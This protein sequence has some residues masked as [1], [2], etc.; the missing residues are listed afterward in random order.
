MCHPFIFPPENH[1]TTTMTHFMSCLLF[2]SLQLLGLTHAGKDVFLTPSHTT[3][4]PVGVVAIEGAQIPNDAYIPLL[5]ALQNASAPEYSVY[6]AIPSFLLDCPNPPQISSKIAGARKELLAAM[7]ATADTKIVG[8]AHSLGAVFLQDFVFKNPTQFSAQ[9]LT[10]AALG[11]KYRNGSTGTGVYPVPTMAIDG[12]LDGL[13]RVTRQAETYFHQ[14]LHPPAA[15]FESSSLSSSSSSSST[16]K[17]D[18]PVV[19]F[20]GVTHMQFASGTP[21]SN[22]AKNDLKPEVTYEQAHAMISGVMSD[23]LR[24]QLGD[25]AKAKIAIAAEVENTGTLLQPLIASLEQEGHHHFHAP[26]NSDY[27]MPAQCPAYPQYPSNNVQRKPQDQEC[28]CGTPFSALAQV[29]MGTASQTPSFPKG[30]SIVAVDAVHDVDEITPV[31][32]PHIWHNCSKSKSSGEEDKVA[33]AAATSCT[34]NVTTVTQPIYATLDTFDTGF[35]YQSASELRVKLKSRQSLLL[36]AGVDPLLIHFN[37][38]DTAGFNCADIN[39]ASYQWALEHAGTKA[40][41]RFEKI[42]EPLIMGKDIFLSNAG[43][44]WIWNPMKYK[45]AKDKSNVVVQ[46]PCSHTPVDYFLKAAAGYHYCKVLSPARAMEWIYIDG[47]RNKG[48][49]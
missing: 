14:V 21:P 2:L 8:F 46:A 19:I 26:C 48:G 43:P 18:F 22:V 32:L 24:S 40:R 5:R 31:H 17:D 3:G 15:A 39:N 25:D 36:A 16:Y 42:G 30:V 20:E 33:A 27:Q 7:N 6:V 13:Y 23:F 9:F 45:E 12:T 49:L 38:T 35:Y 1:P 47:L 28:T 11:R 37:Q 10:G 4:I 44:A 29:V 41:A 34:I